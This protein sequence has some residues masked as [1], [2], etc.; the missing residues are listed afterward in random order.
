SYS[1]PNQSL[2]G[3]NPRLCRRVRH[4]RH[5]FLFLTSTPFHSKSSWTIVKDPSLTLAPSVGNVE[6]K[7]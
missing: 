6:P 2:L 3:Y 5:I 4:R 1:P 7:E